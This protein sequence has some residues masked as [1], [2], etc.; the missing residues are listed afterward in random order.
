M[1][2]SEPL[3]PNS[4]PNLRE[5]LD[6]GIIHFDATGARREAM[7]RAAANRIES[8]S[9]NASKNGSAHVVSNSNEHRNGNGQVHAPAA[10][11]V[12]QPAPL[13]RITP[14]STI[15]PH[16]PKNQSGVSS[17]K[18]RV[19][20]AIGISAK[21]LKHQRPRLNQRSLNPHQRL[22]PHLPFHQ[23]Q[24][25]EPSLNHP[26]LPHSRTRSS[27]SLLT[28]PQSLYP[29]TDLSFRETKFGTSWSTS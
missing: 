10:P 16:G 11:T 2:N 15:P 13:S 6:D 22:R 17:W 27:Q 18:E 14:D 23:R 26:R 29:I 4:Q 9:H 1:S 25:H 5:V 24:L 12:A 28:L 8:S 20:S 3:K 21:L 7:R 19:Q